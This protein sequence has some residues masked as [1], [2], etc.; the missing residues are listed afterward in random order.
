MEQKKFLLLIGS[1]GQL[2]NQIKKNQN[3]I[4]DYDIFFS[5][6]NELDLS[7]EASIKYFFKQEKY[8]LIINCAAYTSVNEAEYEYELANQINNE[9]LKQ[10]SKI[11]KSN[12]LNISTDYVFD[13]NSNMPY[14]ETDYASPINVYGK[15]KL[16]G[17][18]SIINHSLGSINIRTSWLYSKSSN[19]FVN[20]IL[21]YGV[22]KGE[23]DIVSDEIGSPTNANDLAMAIISIINSNNIFKAMK[24]HQVFHY[25]NYGSISRFDFASLIFKL[26]DI[27]CK[28]NPILSKDFNDKVSRPAFS[29]LNS[30]KIN[31]HFDV[32]NYSYFD[33]IK[34]YINSIK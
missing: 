3:L 8:D 5:K 9:S 2:G 26:I 34:K 23:L 6:R 32:K 27:K 17:E 28:I 30:Q 15:T 20:T 18:Q 19:N 11:T 24:S 29:S 14:C 25:A 13:G 10:I 31:S 1:T 7:K 21:K 22:Q 4:K 33:S 12:I 16:D